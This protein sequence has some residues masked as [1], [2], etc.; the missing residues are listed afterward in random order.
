MSFFPLAAPS[1][2]F[3]LPD[4]PFNEVRAAGLTRGEG[5]KLANK[6]V[7]SSCSMTIFRYV[8]LERTS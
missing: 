4:L 6:G 5:D 3:H 1:S 8:R 7:P 2:N